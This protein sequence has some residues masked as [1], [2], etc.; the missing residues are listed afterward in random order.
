M[1]ICLP[2]SMWTGFYSN[3]RKYRNTYR[4]FKSRIAALSYSPSLIL[5]FGQI[6]DKKMLTKDKY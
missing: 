2:I 5:I 6:I 1:K 4:Q 3:P